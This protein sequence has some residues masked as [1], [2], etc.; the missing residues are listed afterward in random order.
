MSFLC[1]SFILSAVFIYCGI[2]Q[3]LKHAKITFENIELKNWFLGLQTRKIWLFFW[4][5][6]LKTWFLNSWENFEWNFGVIRFW[7]FHDLKRSFRGQWGHLTT[8][9]MSCHNFSQNHVRNM[10]I[11]FLDLQ[12][13]KFGE[14]SQFY[15]KIST[16]IIT[17]WSY[18]AL[19]NL[20]WQIEA[21]NSI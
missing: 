12:E 20:L 10:K 13:N 15:V 2:F 19:I 17:L 1:Y 14:K 3:L 16:N 6:N 5:R 11:K 21:L 4:S 18:G 8:K 7:V 9:S